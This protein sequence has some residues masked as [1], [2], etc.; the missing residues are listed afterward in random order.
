MLSLFTIKLDYR[1]FK[2]NVLSFYRS[3]D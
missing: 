2:N 3:H 1:G